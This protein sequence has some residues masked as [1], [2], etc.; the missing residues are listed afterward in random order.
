MFGGQG[1]QTKQWLGTNIC[2]FGSLK[3]QHNNP[4]KH[5]TTKYSVEVIPYRQVV[6]SFSTLLHVTVNNSLGPE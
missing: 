3:H 4:S 5:G 1:K 6:C 2:S